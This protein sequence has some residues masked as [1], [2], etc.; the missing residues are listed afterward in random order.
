MDL[1][2]RLSAA[3]QDAARAKDVLRSMIFQFVIVDYSLEFHVI[4]LVDCP[5]DSLFPYSQLM[6]PQEVSKTEW[7]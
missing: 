6:I 4:L 3:L 5:F 7:T 1:E 2:E